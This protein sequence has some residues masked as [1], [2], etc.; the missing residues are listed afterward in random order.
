V[1]TEQIISSENVSDGELADEFMQG[2]GVAGL[3]EGQSFL[4]SD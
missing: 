3:A 2:P 1:Q 4:L